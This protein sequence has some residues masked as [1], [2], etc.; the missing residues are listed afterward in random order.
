MSLVV[1]V[2]CNEFVV[3]GG[4]GKAVLNNGQ[5]LTDFRIESTN[6]VALKPCHRATFVQN[7][8]EFSNIVFHKKTS[9]S[10][11]VTIVHQ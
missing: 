2:A 4:E 8:Y 10:F 6:C 3:M 7:K 5:I 11:D 1:D 9:L